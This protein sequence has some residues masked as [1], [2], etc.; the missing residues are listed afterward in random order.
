MMPQNHL[1]DQSNENRERRRTDRRAFLKES[2]V[3]FGALIGCLPFPSRTLTSAESSDPLSYL[4]VPEGFEI[5]V[6]RENLDGAE[7]ETSG[8]ANPGPR[9]MA[10]HEGTLFAASPGDP[11][12]DD[13]TAG[14]IYAFPDDSRDGAL[15]VLEEL[16]KPNSLDFH[17]GQLYIG[18][19]HRVLRYE[20]DGLQAIEES[21]AVVVDMETSNENATWSSTI[22][23]HEDN[24]WISRGNAI[25][26]GRE[27]RFREAITKCALDGT[28]CETYATGLRNAVG[29]T[30]SPAG[31]LVATE[32]GMGHTDPDYPPDEINIIEEGGHYG[33]PYCHGNNEPIDPSFVEVP[34]ESQHDDILRDSDVACEDMDEPTVLL[35]AHSAPLGLAFYT[36][37]VFPD[38]YQ[39]DLFVACHGS[40]GIQP[41][42]GYN[43]LRIKWD[44]SYEI[45]DFVTG[46]LGSNGEIR[47][48]PVDVLPGPSGDL[49]ISDD[50]SGRIYRVWFSGR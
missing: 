29:F 14:K 41:P 5:E 3:A 25:G 22:R 28:G 13:T 32:N 33:W 45:H 47:G 40:W 2:G 8:G 50:A 12:G 27:N 17:A 18:T 15:M 16:N 10:F 24:L 38:D 11:Y 49:Y 21:E 19:P 1:E 43:I 26:P 36:G 44:G 9:F 42:A 48:R 35:P 37:T 39:G 30:W 20:M 6:Y 4:E 7:T 34:S 31:E 23:I 46:W